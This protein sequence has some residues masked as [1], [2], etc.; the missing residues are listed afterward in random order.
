LRAVNP[1]SLDDDY[2]MEDED[3]CQEEQKNLTASEETD[4]IRKS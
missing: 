3:H 4:K 1:S 2:E